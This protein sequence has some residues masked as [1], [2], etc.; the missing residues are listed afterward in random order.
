[1]SPDDKALPVY[2]PPPR[3]PPRQQ[4]TRFRRLL[5]TLLLSA[6]ALSLSAYNIWTTEQ[7]RTL[8]KP[9]LRAKEILDQCRSLE[10]E[11]GPPPDFHLRKAS[12]RFVPGTK[13]VLIKNATIWTGEISGY[14]VVKGDL[15]LDKGLIQAIGDVGEDIILK[16]QEL[17]TVDV[18]GS[19]VTPGIVDLHSHLG[20]LSSPS[21]RGSSDGN[22]RKGLVQ[23]WLRS[24]DGLNT[25]DEAYQLTI[26]GGVTTVN[27]LP[28]SANS[29]GGQAFT[30]KLRPTKERSASSMLL[31]PPFTLNGTEFDPS[32]PPRWRQMKHACG[33]NPSRVYSDTR[34]DTIWALRQGYETAR[35]IKVSQDEFCAKAQAG[36]WNEIGD[37]PEDLQWEALVDVLRG[38]VKVQNH[39]YEA[40]DLDGIVRLTNEFKFPLAA[41]HHAHET[42]L[43]PDL[44]KKAYG[45]PPAVAIFAT[46]G[47]YKREAYRGS[48]FAARILADNG[49][50]VVM[51]SDHPVLD[52]RYLVYEAQ[53]AHYYGLPRNLALASVT[54]TPATTMGMDHRIG[55]IK[56]GYDADVVVW[57][58]HPLALGATP[59][60]VYIDGI[61]QLDDPQTL[62]KP[63]SFQSAPETPNFDKEAADAIKYEGLPPLVPSKAKSDVVIFSNVSSL[64]VKSSGTIKQVFGTSAFG[65][66]GVAVVKGGKLICGGASSSCQKSIQAFGQ[67]SETIDIEGGSIAPGLLTFGS[68]LGLR[69]I[70]GEATTSDGV[71]GDPLGSGLP[72]LVGGEGAI[73]RAVDGLQF[74]TRDALI[75]YRSGVT[76]AVVSPLSSGFLSGLG[77][78]FSVGASHALE[79]GAIQK[80]ITALHVAITHASSVSVSTQIAALRRLLLGKAPGELGERAKAVVRGDLPLVVVVDS[81]DAMA[82]LIKLKAEVEAQ[83]EIPIRL[84]FSGANEAHL[85]AE[86]IAAANIGVVLVQYR[87]FPSTW[88]KKR[89]LPGP[90]LSKLTSVTT[91]LAANVTVGVGVE[92]AWNA[93]NT[94]FEIG[95]ANL[96]AQGDLTKA[97]AIALGSVNLEKLLG[98]D[99]DSANND[100]VVTKAGSI[101]DFEAKVVGIVSASKDAVYLL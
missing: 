55:F 42:Y 77:V 41:F 47:R 5:A 86:E 26:S 10:L 48:E 49:L 12:D 72:S 54:T 1:M 46:N 45:H 94:R 58:S 66:R 3:P 56:S 88:E 59:K 83:T 60:Q 89:I 67:S 40:V 7:D 99:E 28:G 32:V 97:D 96:D 19:W 33:E 52:S 93:R 91:L 35:K 11:P 64:F 43:V 101:T 92:E 23:P 17:E 27:V 39:C 85:I 38:R 2:T 84:T 30:I 62:E 16:Y 69:E 65:E 15:L 68:P 20:V 14:E 57:D 37:F 8:A 90:P 79:S 78:A 80:P 98:I 73:I 81:A 22:S 70:A 63:P 75:A 71:V 4:S 9:P 50:N 24:L 100:L 74:S 53:Q 44:L 51:K 21:L 25:H 31:E 87:P 29:I 18:A 61:P 34:M 95:W 36:L 6:L 13:A 76:S 82:S